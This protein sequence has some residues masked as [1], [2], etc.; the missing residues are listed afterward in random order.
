MCVCLLYDNVCMLRL[1]CDRFISKARAWLMVFLTELPV[2]LSNMAW[3][4]PLQK[5]S[6]GQQLKLKHFTQ[7][8]VMRL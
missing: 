7:L 1:R 2:V 5:G 4:V 3:G 6:M 8:A